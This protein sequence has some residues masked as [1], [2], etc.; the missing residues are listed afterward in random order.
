M[1]IMSLNVNRF[2]GMKDRDYTN[3]F[4]HLEQCP[5]A[6]EIIACIKDFLCENPDG[7]V[8]L[9][10]IP[11]RIGKQKLYQEFRSIFEKQYIISEPRQIAKS[12]TLAIWKAEGWKAPGSL[13]G[14]QDEY[15]NK[16]IELVKGME[17]GRN[18][19]L[20]GIHMPLEYSKDVEEVKI[21]D[22]E[23]GEMTIK[24]AKDVYNFF[25]KL[26]TYAK[27]H[28]DELF[29]ILG[30]LNVAKDKPSIYLRQVNKITNVY[31]Y[32][33]KVNEDTITNFKHLTKI[34]RVLVSSALKDK[35]TA[36]V[37]PRYLC[38]LSDHA[39]II[40]NVDL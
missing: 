8:F 37:V 20:L 40:V 14:D 21:S 11:Y 4:E 34:D 22:E 7:V 3:A 16:Y 28:K 12:C 36:Y 38:E 27:E 25:N 19:H 32:S 10:E 6:N 31:G 35:V 5:K 23:I 39:V 9:Y 33:N 29:I 24:C 13:L 15:T 30:D 17:E 26:A 18:L 1:K 2:S